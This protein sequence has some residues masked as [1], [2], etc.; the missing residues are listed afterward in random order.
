[1][2]RQPE[3]ARWGSWDVKWLSFKFGQKLLLPTWQILSGKNFRSILRHPSCHF[4]R[5]KARNKGPHS[6]HEENFQSGM[7]VEAFDEKWPDLEMSADKLD[8]NISPGRFYKHLQAYRVVK[9][10]QFLHT[11]WMRSSRISKS[12]CLAK[13]LDKFCKLSTWQQLANPG[14]QKVDSVER[15]RFFRA[16]SKHFL[17]VLTACS[18]I[19]SL[20]REIQAVKVL[21]SPAACYVRNQLSYLV[22]KSWDLCGQ[23]LGNTVVVYDSCQLILKNQGGSGTRKLYWTCNL[24]ISAAWETP[25]DA[26]FSW[27]CCKESKP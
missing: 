3:I 22:L 7:V 8:R 19:A 2:F 17:Q 23:H 21:D 18:C 11:F 16:F 13:V 14:H 24:P 12:F 1:M 10:P 20:F 5:N 27:L 6:W 25:T 9:Y 26:V 4:G 15:F